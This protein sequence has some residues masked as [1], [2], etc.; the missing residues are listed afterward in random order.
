[1]PAVMFSNVPHGMGFLKK[2]AGTLPFF[3]VEYDENGNEVINILENTYIA[4]QIEALLV[5]DPNRVIYYDMDSHLGCAARNATYQLCNRGAQDSG[6]AQD[7][8]HKIGA[9]QALLVFR[10]Q[11]LKE[12]KKVSEIRP[13]L[14][15]YDP[16]DGYIWGGFKCHLNDPRV[17]AEGF[18]EKVRNE[19]LAEKKVFSTEEMM[20]DK[21]IKALLAKSVKHT[22]DFRTNYAE[23][24][25]KNWVAITELYDN[26]EGELFGII[27][28]RVSSAYTNSGWR[29][30]EPGEAD[31]LLGQVVS[32]DVLIH[33]A[34]KTLL[35]LVSRYSVAGAGHDWP[36]AN[37]EEAFLVVHEGGYPPFDGPDAFGIFSHSDLPKI[38][39]QIKLAQG[40]VRTLR[41]GDN[42][43]KHVDMDMT[44]EELEAA[45]VMVA[46]KA[47][48]RRISEEGWEAI[49][50]IPQEKMEAFF[51]QFKWR[52][53]AA[54]T[55]DAMKNK[56]KKELLAGVKIDFDDGDEF[57]N[58]I[59]EIYERMHY[60]TTATASEDLRDLVQQGSLVMMNLVLDGDRMPRVILPFIV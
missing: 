52:R 12:G 10:E 34:K 60:I 40:L 14:F 56:I 6:L 48:N 47:V 17:V 22:A 24:L 43:P 3:E 50:A 42:Y 35:N 21:K 4:Q 33:Q 53:G 57:I 38:V 20:S 51:G 28:D 16:H 46:N 58:S 49:E 30:G 39:E 19:L 31:D 9:F 45:P 27:L 23:S 59:S 13:S 2:A 1:M 25:H 7:V 41:K 32:Q 5:A 29:I 36:F 11:L 54:L 26:G 44:K 8:G 55:P 15:S 18:S 37:H